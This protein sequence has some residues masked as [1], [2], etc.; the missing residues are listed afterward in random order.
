[1]G[2]QVAQLAGRAGGLEGARRLVGEDPQRLQAFAGR[3]TAV[4]GV[5]GPEQAGDPPGVVVEGHEQPVVAPGVR[6][7]A[8]A[9]R[10]VEPPAGKPEAARGRTGGQEA[11]L[12]CAYRADSTGARA[13][14]ESPGRN[15]VR[16]FDTD[17]RAQ[18]QA[19]VPGLVGQEHGDLLEGQRLRDPLAHGAEQG[20]DGGVGAEAGRDAEEVVQGALVALG[21]LRLL[22][23]AEDDA[24]V[25][26]QAGRIS[27]LCSSGRRPERGSS[28]DSTPISAPPAE[29]SGANRP[30]SGCQV[31]GFDSTGTAGR[32]VL[33]SS[34]QSTAPWGRWKTPWAWWPGRRMGAA[35]GAGACASPGGPRGPPGCRGRRPPRS[36]PRP[37]GRGRRPPCGSAGPGPSP[38]PSARAA[39][40][41][42]PWSAGV[43]SPRA[44]AGARSSRSPSHHRQLPD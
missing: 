12:P 44:R 1:M 28:T 26:G 32:E 18:A 10:V 41:R 35:T 11:V 14:S 23:R 38:R 42:R 33:P 31:P 36:R 19:V 37:A 5:V 6:A 34:S 20:G 21:G 25:G 40:R 4:G 13:A 43:R 39:R 7:A 2:G 27:S 3:K 8:V 9:H 22:G 15:T 17:L 24:G 30:S 16:V 29:R